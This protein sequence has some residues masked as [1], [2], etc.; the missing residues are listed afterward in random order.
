MDH[1][2]Y[3][4]ALNLKGNGNSE[5][6]QLVSKIDRAVQRVDEPNSI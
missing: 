3:G 4:F 5:K 6:R 2:E 1:T